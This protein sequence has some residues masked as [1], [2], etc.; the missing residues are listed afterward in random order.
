MAKAFRGGLTLA[1]LFE[2]H[3]E[4]RIFFPRL[5]FILLAR[6]TGWNVRA[7]M[8]LIVAA[9]CLIAWTLQLLL[10]RTW[11]EQPVK[12]L[13]FS[14]RPEPA[15][16]FPDPAPELAVGLSAPVPRSDSVFHRAAGAPR[17]TRPTPLDGTRRGLVLREHVLAGCWVPGVGRGAAAPAREVAAGEMGPLGAA[18]GDGTRGLS[19]SL[20]AWLR[21]APAQLSGP[22]L[23]RAPRPVCPLVRHDARPAA[24][25]R[26]R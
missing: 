22:A 15:G 12:A 25:A 20:P 14:L 23:L 6:L 26:L 16:V 10:R 17:A 9:A 5:L 19:R 2:P 8:G 13:L 21:A 7:E 24:R 3:N 18:L 11:P 1:D 4:H